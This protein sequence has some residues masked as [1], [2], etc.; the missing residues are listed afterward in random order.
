MV[1][2][3]YTRV[4][5]VDLTNHSDIKDKY[6]S[7]AADVARDQQWGYSDIAKLI[8]NYKIQPRGQFSMMVCWLW[9]GD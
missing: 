8:E 7:T 3:R 1:V 2:K 9:E 5:R 6:G 4:D